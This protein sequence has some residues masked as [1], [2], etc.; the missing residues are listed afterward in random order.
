VTPDLVTVGET[1]WTFATDD[2]AP[3][4][5]GQR[6]ATMACG[7]ESNVAAGVAALGLAA[8]WIGR[9]GDDAFGRA[10][11]A[12]LGALGVDCSLAVVDRERPTGLMFKGAVDGEACEI[13]Y[14]RRGS[15]GSRLSPTDLDAA[16]FAGARALHL[17]GITACLSASAAAAT[18]RALELAREVGAWCSFDTNLRPQLSRDDPRARVRGLVSRADVCFAGVRDAELLTGAETIEEAAA[19]LAGLGPSTVVVTQGSRGAVAWSEDELLHA[20]PAAVVP[21]DP[22]GAGDAFA[23]GFLGGRLQDLSTPE[24]LALGARLG[25]EATTSRRDAVPGYRRT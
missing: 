10:V 19:G 23:A 21:V 12:E 25:A 4:D 24:C 16:S 20:E 17:T 7:A 5:R 11:L 14:A 1:M 6:F 18:E 22:V 9:V 15:A 3:L 8:R 2:L 13:L